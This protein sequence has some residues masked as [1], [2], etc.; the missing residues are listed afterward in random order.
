M[1]ASKRKTI[2][3]SLW[4]A[5]IALAL[6][7]AAVLFSAGAALADPVVGNSGQLYG[8]D[9]S[10]S[11]GPDDL[12]RWHFTPSVTNVV[13]SMRLYATSPGTNFTGWVQAGY[14]QLDTGTLWAECGFYPSSL[15]GQGNW[16]GCSFT[17]SGGGAY[18]PFVSTSHSYGLTFHNRPY[19]GLG[20]SADWTSGGFGLDEL[21]CARL[22]VPFG[23]FG[24][25]CTGFSAT[26]QVQN[27]LFY[28]DSLPSTGVLPDAFGF[29]NNAIGPIYFSPGGGSQHAY[30]NLGQMFVSQFHAVGTGTFYVNTLNVWLNGGVTETRMHQFE[31]G[32]YTNTSDRNDPN[33]PP[34]GS[35]GQ[36]GLTGNNTVCNVNL[37]VDYPGSGWYFC[38]I[39]GTPVYGGNDY[40]LGVDP[41]FA[42]NIPSPQLSLEAFPDGGSC[43]NS[44]VT[45]SI[46][47][48][49][50]RWPG[51]NECR[52]WSIIGLVAV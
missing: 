13:G 40:W 15:P 21:Q 12:E 31:L 28:M 41:W 50:T 35:S 2:A 38:T 43:A 24:Q 20:Y 25:Y 1:H 39:P 34:D 6:T 52:N 46:Y 11:G 22:P 36:P 30:L 4:L 23:P 16:N 42:P 27:M 44:L 45:N 26:P 37:G 18:T 14:Y 33:G 8:G 17:T 51:Y 9:L 7:L 32:L 48:I 10:I 19:R 29:R 47:A 49:P 3:A 5:T